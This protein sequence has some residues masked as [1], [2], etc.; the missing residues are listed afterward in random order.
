MTGMLLRVGP[1]GP[2]RGNVGVPGDKSIAHRW[3]ILAATARSDS[4][5]EGL[6]RSMDVRS[7]ASC[8]TGL[9]PRP[10]DDLLA[11]LEEAGPGPVRIRGQGF[12]GLAEPHGWLDCGNSGTTM[13]LL[14]GILAGRAFPSVLDGD[15]SLRRRPMER[16]AEPLRGMGAEV[17]TREGRPPLSIQGGLLQGIRYLLPVASAQVKA[18]VLFAG[19][20]ASGVTVVEE[21]L[22]T[23][24]HTE[25]AL[26]ALAAPVLRQGKRI[27]LRRF[28][29]EGFRGRVPGDPS[30]AAFLLAAAALRPGSEVIVTDV[31]TNPSRLAYLD[32]LRRAGA[33]VEV[34]TTGESLGE[35]HGRIT[36][37]GG[38]LR[39]VEVSS[40]ELVG[41][42]DE[43]PVL[44][45]MA[46]HA[47]GASRFEGVDELRVKE[48]DRVAGIV[49]GV[50][51]LGGGAEATGDSL[52]VDGGGLAG[53]E[54]DAR[55]DHRLAMAFSVGALAARRPST[56]VGAEWMDVSFPGFA[57]A[58]GSLGADVL[59]VTA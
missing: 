53:G 1:S 48:S 23:R 15:E 25:R 2:L 22:P 56:V 26:A 46:A 55:G 27:E 36:L 20:Q 16:V 34:S 28:Q 54:A 32:V 30:S 7:T 39:A 3:L 21:D 10:A 57:Q 4:E 31:G 47:P 41:I 40:R 33:E 58:L 35:P 14:A 50:R 8:L 6:P 17:R 37:R 43:V 44:A 29:H 45:V 13:R 24:D 51:A 11:W 49:T 59:Q 9:L 5:L 19:L 18:A 42:V 38:D 12:E 52:V